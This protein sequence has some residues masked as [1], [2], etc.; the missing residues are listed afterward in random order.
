MV[1]HSMKGT[2]PLLKISRGLAC[3]LFSTAKSS[4]LAKI[5]MLP[6]NKF[7]I[8]KSK[9][10]P[11]R[12]GR[13]RDWLKIKTHN[14]QEVIICGFTAPEGSRKYF[15]SLILGVYKEGHLVYA[16]HTGSGFNQA[17]LKEIYQKLNPLI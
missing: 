8:T 5:K 2:H 10:S 7:K 3:E 9:E 17:D 16:G 1:T 13:S 15:G 11:Y 14:Q 6:F 12:E 4:S